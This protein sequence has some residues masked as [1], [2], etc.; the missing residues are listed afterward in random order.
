MQHSTAA[1][2]ST[3]EIL[4]S[5]FTKVAPEDLAFGS[6]YLVAVYKTTGPSAA[7]GGARRTYT[8]HLP[9]LAADPRF[10]VG[11]GFAAATPGPLNLT[12]LPCEV[13]VEF[14]DC[15]CVM[16]QG[17]LVRHRWH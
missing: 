6:D 4:G 14:D 16:L 3:E 2:L 7:T 1:Q 8:S 17:I 5:G 12:Q 15:L 9:F 11:G 10:L 13:R